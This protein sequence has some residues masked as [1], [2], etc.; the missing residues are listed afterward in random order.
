LGIAA[1]LAVQ[2]C[3]TLQRLDAVPPEL[4]QKALTAGGP[5]AR[6]WFDSDLTDIAND[7]IQSVQRERAAL[8]AAG[9]PVDPMPPAHF[10]AISGGGDAGAFGAGVLLGW[11]DLG[12]RPEFKI[13]TGVSTGGLI[14]PFAYLGP[15]YDHV[16]RYVYT[17]ISPKDVYKSRGIIA[18]F[19][20]DGLADNRPLWGLIAKYITPEFLAEV[21]R[22]HEKGRFLLIGTTNLDARRPVVW[23][24]GAIASSK[25]PRAIDLFRD[26]M[27][28]SA[29]IPGAF[30]P[31]MIDVE[32]DGKRYQEMHVDGGAIAQ[33]FL[34]PPSLSDT[35]RSTGQ[36]VETRERHAYIIRNSG[37][38]PEWAATERRTMSILGRAINSMLQM[39]GIGDIYRVYG[40]TQ[41]DGVDFNLAFI[42]TDFREPHKE[43]FDTEYMRKLFDYGYQLSV[44]GYPWQKSPPGTGSSY[45]R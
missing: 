29:A 27:L 28:A 20:S 44:K 39:Q 6:Y 32:L 26:I 5:N 21:A 22:E 45:R 4:T 12:T 41:K 2:G 16:L 3:A 23:N 14:A 37:F 33:L 42:G 8:L 43:E 31:V 30:S 17:S 38:G 11:T 7:G 34:Y 15:K 1:V 35:V 18:A 10:L 24:M 19:T 13:V 40:T 36:R 9:K 25:D